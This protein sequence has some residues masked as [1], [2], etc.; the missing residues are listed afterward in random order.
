MGS[1]RYP[2]R[3]RVLNC[4]IPNDVGTVLDRNRDERGQTFSE[5]IRRSILLAEQIRAAAEDGKEFFIFDPVDG[6][7]TKVMIL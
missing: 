1:M 3:T 7:T 2:K 4:H 5:T 6:S